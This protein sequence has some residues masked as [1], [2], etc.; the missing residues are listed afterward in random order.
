MTK[1]QYFLPLQIEEL[2]DGRFL[3]RSVQLP[4]LNVQGDSIE[5]VLRLAPKVAQSLIA[6]MR[7]KGVPIPRGLTAVRAPL[8]VKVLVAV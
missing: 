4:G 5:D 6:A 1:Q 8:R 2:G 7:T 3:G